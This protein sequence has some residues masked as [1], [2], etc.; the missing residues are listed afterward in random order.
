MLSVAAVGMFGYGV[1]SAGGAVT[2]LVFAHRLEIWADVNALVFGLLLVLLAHVGGK[3]APGMS[4]SV[5][6]LLVPFIL[7]S[8]VI[9]NEKKPGGRPTRPFANPERRVPSPVCVSSGYA[10]PLVEPQLTHL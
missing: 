3:Q 2:D 6:G 4:W 5:A 8:L 1:W 7:P 9:R 10:Q